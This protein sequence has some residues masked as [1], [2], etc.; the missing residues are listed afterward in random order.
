MARVPQEEIERLKSEVSLER[1]VAARGVKLTKKGEDLVGLCPFHADREPSLIVTPEKNLWHC[2]GACQA[3][4]TVIDWVMRVEGVSFRLAVEML[5]VGAATEERAL[6]GAPPKRTARAKVATLEARST[7]DAELLEQVL[8]VYE[9]TLRESPEGHEFLKRRGLE[10]PEVV[11]RFR[12]GFSNRTLG[13]RLPRTTNAGVETRKRLEGLGVMRGSGH[14]HMTGSL[15]IPLFDEAGRVVQLYGRK[16]GT[17]L[18]VDVPRHLYLSGGHRGVFNGKELEGKDEVI[19]CEALIDALTFWCAGYRNVTSAYGVEGLTEEIVQALV[20][21]GV[22]SVKIA[23]DRDEGGE[24]GAQ[25]ASERLSA[26]GIDTYRVL[27]PKGMDA[28]E[29]ARKVG[30]ADKSLGLVLRQALWMARGKV[31]VASSVRGETAPV[32]QSTPVAGAPEETRPVQGDSG[33]AARVVAEEIPSLAAT[34]SMGEQAKAGF[35]PA[36]GE[37]SRATPAPAE[38]AAVTA[39]EVGPAAGNGQPTVDKRGDELFVA[40]GERRWRVRPVGKHTSGELRVNILVT[41]EHDSAR[42]FVDTV[43]LYSARQRGSFTKQAAEELRARET[44]VRRE[45]GQIVLEV[46][47]KRDEAAT[48][49]SSKPVDPAAT[50]SERER[51]EALSLLRDPGLLDRIL[52]DMA[53]A[54][55]VGEETNKLVAYLAATSRK[56]GEPLAVVIQSSSAAGKSSLMDAVLAL[57]PEEERVQYSAMTGQSLFYMSGENLKHKVLAIVEEEGAERASYALKLL[58][59]EGELTIASTGKDPATGRHVTQTYRVEGPVMIFLTTTAIEVDEELL[60]R[61]LVLAVDEGRKQTRAIHA[62]QRRGETLEGLIERDERARIRRVHKNAQRLLRP[63]A[64]VNPFALELRFADHATRT[65]RDHMKYLTLIRAVALLHQHQRPV[66]TVENR[67]RKIEYIEAT[68]E[69]IAVAT[70]LA[71]AVLGRSLD[72]LPPQTRRLA[73]LIDAMVRARC[74]REKVERHEIRFSR[75]AVREAIGWSIE[76]LRVHL[77]RL[78]ELEY[79]IVHR[80]RR[81]QSFEYELVY[82]GEGKA[83]ERFLVGLGTSGESSTCPTWGGPEGG[84]P[85]SNRGQTGVKPGGEEVTSMSETGIETAPRAISTLNGAKREVRQTAAARSVASS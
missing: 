76:Q 21:A 26:V 78:V 19:L 9:A 62:R 6:Q 60:N 44:E 27:F 5:R 30:P 29:Y 53:R 79:V 2:M 73:D 35:E 4:G 22:R 50:M 47:R 1:L 48:A 81:G 45:L 33:E 28:N 38:P 61:C 18:R 54:G 64:V 32:T 67:G 75:R 37:R 3:G 57:M 17:H 69:D 80:G 23:F 10:H 8:G 25:K 68:R 71:H 31:K 70:R 58:Q 12:L 13:Y 74:D 16:V 72:E 82:E 42:S 36:R 85:G 15:V 52:Q 63:I 7:A 39:S 46:E 51:E 83:G 24:R 41:V 49:A 77:G 43:D 20:K 56:L 34:S 66:R 11:E 84:L 40:F 59:S 65:R 14:E 55:V